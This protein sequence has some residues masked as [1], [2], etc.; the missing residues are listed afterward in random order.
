MDKLFKSVWII[1]TASDDE[2]SRHLNRVD[3]VM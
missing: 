1:N 2:L 3:P